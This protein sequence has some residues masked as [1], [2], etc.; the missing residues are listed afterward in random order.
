MGRNDDAF[1]F[2]LFGLRNG[3]FCSFSVFLNARSMAAEED[4]K[5]I[6]DLIAHAA[7]TRDLVAGTIIG[8]GTVS[9]AAYATVGSACLSEKRA[10]EMIEDGA[11]KTPFLHFGDRVTMEV[12]TARGSP[13][14]TI[15]QRVI[16]A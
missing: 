10:I 13:F 5:L 6:H 3:S 12:E 16:Q 15:D 1:A 2:F 9:N 14:G 8:S 11:P 7:R 4:R